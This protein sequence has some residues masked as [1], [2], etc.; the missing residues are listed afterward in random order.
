F[1]SSLARS[2]L[3]GIEQLAE[4]V[5][6]VRAEGDLLEHADALLVARARADDLLDVLVVD[7]HLVEL[8][9]LPRFAR[10]R[11]LALPEAVAPLRM[12]VAD[13][14]HPEAEERLEVD[15]PLLAAPA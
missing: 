13:P 15:D 7:R 6:R 9:G 10:H 2:L 3:G 14:L 12:H 5:A 11:E 4:A 1:A 8:G